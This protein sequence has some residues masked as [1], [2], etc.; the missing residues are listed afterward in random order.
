MRLMGVVLFEQIKQGVGLAG[1]GSKDVATTK[2]YVPDYRTISAWAMNGKPHAGS[3][4]NPGLLWRLPLLAVAPRAEAALKRK[5]TRM[6]LESWQRLGV[7]CPCSY[8]LL[9]TQKQSLLH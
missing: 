6:L 9:A 2:L 1:T 4:V 7:W 3:A 5:W 8:T